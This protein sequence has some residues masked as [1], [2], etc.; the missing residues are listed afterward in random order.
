MNG[1]VL[2]MTKQEIKRKLDEII[3]F[4]GVEKYIDTPVK[5]YSSG[6]TVRLGFA[7]AAFLEPEILVVDEV[8]TVG[9]AEFQKRAI[10]KMDD[11]AKGGRTVLF[12]SHNMRA[13]KNLC[14]NGILLRNGLL[15]YIG[16]AEDCVDRYL[17]TNID[18]IVSHIVLT[19]ENRTKDE[20]DVVH[21][22][23]MLEA[24]LLNSHPE[25]MATDEDIMVELLIKRN[26]SRRKECQYSIVIT[27]TTDTKVLNI[28]SEMIPIPF[29]RDTYKVRLT[30]DHHGLPG[31]RYKIHIAIGRK[32]FSGALIN[33]DIAFDL[34]SFEI[35]YITSA[36]KKEY[37]RYDRTWGIILHNKENIKAEI[38]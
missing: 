6:M 1:A 33:Y 27:D 8:L 29:D 19:K 11:V 18:D 30:A 25:A 24:T 4:A 13:V 15:D 16:T 7:V 12:V 37:F 9:D 32:D 14:K 35:K 34:L 31:G 10:G 20:C 21:D 23:E 38:I 28:V 2:G 3:D 17:D 26:S 5:R 22:I 36:E